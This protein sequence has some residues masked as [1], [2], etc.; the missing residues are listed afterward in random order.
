MDLLKIILEK[1]NKKTLPVS[2]EKILGF[3]SKTFGSYQLE[4]DT[5]AKEKFYSKKRYEELEGYLDLEDSDKKI[6]DKL[7]DDDKTSENPTLK[8]KIKAQLEILKK[9]GVINEKKSGFH[10]EEF[11]KK[12][13]SLRIDPEIAS[14]MHV[15]AENSLTGRKHTSG[16]LHMITNLTGASSRKL[17]EELIDE[18]PHYNYAEKLYREQDLEKD[19]NKNL[20][21]ILHYID[22]LSYSK[23]SSRYKI[24]PGDVYYFATQIRTI[25]YNFK[26]IVEFWF[27]IAT[28]NDDKVLASK[29]D[30]LIKELVELELRTKHG[31]KDTHLHLVKIH[32]I[33]RVKAGTL[34]QA[35]L[36]TENALKK[37]TMK[38]LTEID[39]IGSKDAETIMKYVGEKL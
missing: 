29:Y 22:G 21:I 6:I 4:H 30:V 15:H 13:F 33:G 28:D 32:N 27:E 9:C 37:A 31:V 3:F 5:L 12:V 24:E 1:K 23:M 35:G 39:K 34:Y 14:K 26:K 19:V 10:I 38:K 8:Q 20:Q 25:L 7:F 18:L 11:G 16:I 17:S 36:K 2:F